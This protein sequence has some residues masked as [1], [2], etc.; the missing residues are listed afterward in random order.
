MGNC[1]DGAHPIE[2][3]PQ[4]RGNTVISSVNENDASCEFDQDWPVFSTANDNIRLAGCVRWW[5]YVFDWL[6]S[7]GGAKGSVSY[8]LT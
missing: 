6:F 3:D 5:K 2:S 8:R 1:R 7:D 4:P